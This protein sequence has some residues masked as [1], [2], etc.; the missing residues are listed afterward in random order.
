MFYFDISLLDCSCNLYYAQFTSNDPMWV[1][2]MV[3]LYDINC[4]FYYWDWLFVLLS[5]YLCICIYTVF[6]NIPEISSISYM[7]NNAA[8]CRVD[9]SSILSIE[10]FEII[11]ILKWKSCDTLHIPVSVC[12]DVSVKWSGFFSK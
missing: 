6:K 8:R 9:R 12:D 3:Y 10:A 5:S 4:A 1:E 7:Y 11:M 2:Y